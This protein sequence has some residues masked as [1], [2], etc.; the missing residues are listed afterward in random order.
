[1]IRPDVG[2]FTNLGD[3]HQEHFSDLGQKL[4]RKLI[5]FRQA[6]TIIYNASDPH[7]R[8]ALSANYT[9]TV[10]WRVSHPK[11][12]ISSNIA[13]FRRC[14]AGKCRRSHRTV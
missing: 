8:A 12:T 6:Q 3:A 5:L 11:A 13:F 14:F 1:M 10:N 2:I 7:R 9:E 4:N